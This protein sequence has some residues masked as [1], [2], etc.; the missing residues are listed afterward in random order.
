MYFPSVV[1][2]LHVSQNEKTG[3]RTDDYKSYGV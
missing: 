3:R 2:V 1:R